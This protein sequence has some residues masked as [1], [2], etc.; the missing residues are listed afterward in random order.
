M[1]ILEL[2]INVFRR[3][4]WAVLPESFAKRIDP[5]SSMADAISAI[6]AIFTVVLFLYLLVYISK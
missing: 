5:D 3:L 2:V 1:E 4:I 6:V